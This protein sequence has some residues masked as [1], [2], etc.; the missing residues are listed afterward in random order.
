MSASSTAR[1]VRAR[2]TAR[3]PRPGNGHV[4]RRRPA[5]R[6]QPSRNAA[7]ALASRYG[8]S[9]PHSSRALCIDRIADADVDGR[10][11]VPGRGD[12]ADRGAAGHRVVGDERLPGHA[13]L[14]AGGGEHGAAAAV[15]GVA[16]V[17]V[18]LEDRAAVGARVVRRV[19]PLGVVGVHGVAG[20]GG[21][22]DGAGEGA[23]PVL[24]AS[25]R[26]RSTERSR[27]VPSSGPSAPVSDW[28]AVLLVVEGGQHR[29][30]RQVVAGGRRRRPA[31]PSPACTES[32]LSIRGPA[33][34]SRSRP[35]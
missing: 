10:D 1:C 31:R 12:R 21:E 33:S 22:A 5:G 35:R 8:S 14:L 2:C 18:D 23:G 3:V 7:S 28:R 25:R 26:G 17:D 6:A 9:A 29:D 20:V 27:T 4:G 13:R 15:G 32:R 16:L 34:S 24:V 30:V 19:V 11:A